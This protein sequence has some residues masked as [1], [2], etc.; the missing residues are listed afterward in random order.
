M[1]KPTKIDP[2][3]IIRELSFKCDFCQEEGII[4]KPLEKNFLNLIDINTIQCPNCNESLG[5]FTHR[6]F[7]I[8]FNN[9]G[10]TS[11]SNNIK[12]SFS[13]LIYEQSSKKPSLILFDV[14][15]IE[16]Q[17]FKSDGKE[18]LDI[19]NEAKK[20]VHYLINNDKLDRDYTF[21]F[22]GTGTFIEGS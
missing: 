13:V 22:D 17:I 7:N 19:Y 18:L 11:E 8:R 9:F 2:L 4:N 21:E 12:Y 10:D 20:E 3:D 5:G 15:S 16:L 6:K 1:I 14:P